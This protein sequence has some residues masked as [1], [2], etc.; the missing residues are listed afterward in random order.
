MC[1]EPIIGQECTVTRMRDGKL[2]KHLCT[3]TDYEY[4]AAD[5]LSITVQFP[6]GIVQKMS[7]RNVRLLPVPGIDEQSCSSPG[8]D[9][10]KFFV[11]FNE[12]NPLFT[13]VKAVE[14]DDLDGLSSFLAK[15]NGGK[16]MVIKG[17]EVKVSLHV[18]D[19]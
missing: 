6:D 3:I 5:S 16:V 19:I 2:Q 15:R 13:T 18:E 8:H 11:C 10:D 7:S 1:N 4:G 17:K 14:F 9:Q 12:T